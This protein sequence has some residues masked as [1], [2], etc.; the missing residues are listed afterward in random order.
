MRSQITQEELNKITNDVRNHKV[1]CDLKLF[2]LLTDIV[3][4]HDFY[5]RSFKLFKQ[6]YKLDII[7]CL[8]VLFSATENGSTIYEI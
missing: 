7:I 8:I 1:E 2:K 4:L 5:D 3:H 6:Y